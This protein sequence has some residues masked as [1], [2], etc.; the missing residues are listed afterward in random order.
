MPEREADER[1]LG[2]GILAV[3]HVLERRL[4]V[5]HF[6][7]FGHVRLVVKVIKVAG[8]SLGI[9]LGDERRT[10]LADRWPVD[11]GEVGV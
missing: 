10:L 8:V 6:L 2:H 9:E 11:F 1:T 3:G 4:L 7:V 5:V